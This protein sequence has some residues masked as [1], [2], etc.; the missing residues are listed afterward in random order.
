MSVNEPLKFAYW[1]PNVSGGLVVSTIEQRTSHDPA[2]NVAVAQA[3][4]RVG[5]EYALTQV[6]YLASYGAD[7]QHGRPGVPGELGDPRPPAGSADHDAGHD[8]H[9]AG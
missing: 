5:F 6:R 8:H 9:R 4:E 3:A 7:A 1:V 2:Y